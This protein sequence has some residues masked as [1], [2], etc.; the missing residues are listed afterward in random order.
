MNTT[1]SLLVLRAQNPEVTRDF[2]SALGLTFEQE[3][4]G[5]GPLHYAAQSEN[6][7][8]EIYPLASGQTEITDSVQLGFQVKSLEKTVKTL[9]TA[10]RIKTTGQ[11]GPFCVLQDPDG[12]KVRLT[13]TPTKS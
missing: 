2:Y 11:W 13:E 4:H 3:Q 12:R 1:L 9:G 6:F 7:V 8:L 5:S 10:E